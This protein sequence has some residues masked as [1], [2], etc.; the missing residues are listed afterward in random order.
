MFHQNFPLKVS[1]YE[2]KDFFSASYLNEKNFQKSYRFRKIMNTVN[3]EEHL[4][5]R[6][7]IIGLALFSRSI[8]G[9]DCNYAVPSCTLL[10]RLLSRQIT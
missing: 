9:R 8:F 5:S 6:L 1:L 4:E 7:I 2:A 3:C 10:I